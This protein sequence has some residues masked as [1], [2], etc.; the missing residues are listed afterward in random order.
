MVADWM[1]NDPE[2]L[3]VERVEQLGSEHH[4]ETDYFSMKA[5]SLYFS[6]YLPTAMVSEPLLLV[7]FVGIVLY[8][9]L[10]KRKIYAVPVLVFY[11]ILEWYL[12]SVGRAG[13]HRVDYGILFALAASLIFLSDVSMPK[14]SESMKKMI[15]FG[16]VPAAALIGVFVICTYPVSWHITDR[17]YFR[18][19]AVSLKE[20]TDNGGYQYMVHPIALGLNKDRN[21]YDLPSDYNDGF[22]YMGG[23]QE[24]IKIPGLSDTSLCEIDGNPWEE[25]V[26]SDTIRLV[27]KIQ[28]G[29]VCI[30]EI[31]MYIEKNYGHA[32]Q[33]ILEFQNVDIVVYRVVSI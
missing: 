30:K 9:A 20:A 4:P 6:R 26:D 33:G 10:S 5:P 3:T 25:C 14:I 27:F 23:W 15:R 19:V 12:F 16:A 29:E 17:E 1:N 24:G 8:L 11:A 31:A 21:I 18:S 22:F 28:D 7:S 13:V 32:V 2:V